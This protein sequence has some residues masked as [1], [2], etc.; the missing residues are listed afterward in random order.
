MKQPKR[1]KPQPHIKPD[2]ETFDQILTRVTA[3][4][5]DR[6]KDGRQFFTGQTIKR[7]HKAL[8]NTEALINARHDLASLSEGF[9]TTSEMWV[10]ENAAQ[11]LAF[12]PS[13]AI[14]ERATPASGQ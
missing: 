9:V 12:S 1:P 8:R 6:Q 2:V 4:M 14:S 13:P 11:N 7:R 3:N 5:K 10:M